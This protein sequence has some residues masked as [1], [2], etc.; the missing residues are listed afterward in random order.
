MSEVMSEVQ[1]L[2]QF[3]E[4]QKTLVTAGLQAERL[5]E[6]KDFKKLILDGFCLHEAARYAQE[7][8]DPMLTAEQRQDALNMAQ[9]SGHLKRFLQITCKMGQTAAKNVRDAGVALD[10]A[11]AEAAE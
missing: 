2:E 9:A 10:E 1:Q 8:G 11:R 6:N 4:D 7:S 3:I 5:A